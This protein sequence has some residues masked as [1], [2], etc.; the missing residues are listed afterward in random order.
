MWLLYA[1][2]HYPGGRFADRL[3]RKTVL[4]IGL[5]LTLLGFLTLGLARTYNEFLLGA[6]TVGIG[7]GLY[8]I[9]MR[10]VIFDTAPRG[11]GWAI[12]M[13]MAAGNIGAIIAAGLVAFVLTDATWQSA[14]LVVAI[15]LVLPFVFVHYWL[16]EPYTIAPV[17]LGL[18]TTTA[19]VF[20]SSRIRW[21][22]IA[23][24]LVIFVWQGVLGFLPTFLQEAKAF[25]PMFAS[26]GFALV[27][28]VGILVMPL[29]GEISDRLPR[30]AVV[31][32]AL[33]CC[34]AGLLSLVVVSGKVFVLAAVAIFA[35]GLMSFPSAMQA[36]LLGIFPRGSI[37]GDFGVFKTIYTGLGA[38]GPI[39]VG[40]VANYGGYILSYLT[41]IVF[42]GLA[43]VILLGLSGD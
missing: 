23:Y 41:L 11:Q 31:L 13:N 6:S 39:Y 7:A 43:V 33:I 38:L 32:G 3:S 21:L 5:F 8:F 19:R 25:S 4:G 15:S 16:H 30:I 10:V 28:V 34:G 17:E 36:Y 37:G 26:G 29:S 9:T 24:S 12:G 1:A 35:A 27:W 20:R 2:V 22:V 14:F 40:V 18:R 42:L